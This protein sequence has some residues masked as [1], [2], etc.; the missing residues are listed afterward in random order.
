MRAKVYGAHRLPLRAGVMLVDNQVETD[1][2]RNPFLDYF[3]LFQIVL[4]VTEKLKSPIIQIWTTKILTFRFIYIN[5]SNPLAVGSFFIR[6][7]EQTFY[8][9]RLS[10]SQYIRKDTLTP[11]FD[12]DFSIL[13]YPNTSFHQ[14]PSDHI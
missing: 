13:Q 7:F 5:H 14:I 11:C 9:L 4:I 8:E 10:I 1:P 6:C 12:M 3:I 2:T